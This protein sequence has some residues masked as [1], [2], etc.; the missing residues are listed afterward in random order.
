VKDDNLTVREEEGKEEETRGR[1]APKDHND[2]PTPQKEGKGEGGLA[3]S[4]GGKEGWS[5]GEGGRGEA[6]QASE[7]GKGRKKLKH[8]SLPW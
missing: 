4:T 2:Y 1:E 6:F 8:V 3:K 7:R 5:G